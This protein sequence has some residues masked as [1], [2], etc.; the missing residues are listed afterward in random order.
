VYNL[1]ARTISQS[2]L[3]N[4]AL[5]NDRLRLKRPFLGTR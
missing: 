2:P 1:N 4:T 3:I 5:A